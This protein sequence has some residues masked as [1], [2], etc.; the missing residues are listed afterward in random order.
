MSEQASLPS[1][2]P[3]TKLVVSGNDSFQRCEEHAVT[4]TRALH[5]FMRP[6]HVFDIV[7]GAHPVTPCQKCK[8]DYYDRLRRSQFCQANSAGEAISGGKQTPGSGPDVGPSHD[9][10]PQDTTG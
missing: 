3:A 5:A 2:P 6:A 9:G 4:I 8:D 7:P 10:D 1:F